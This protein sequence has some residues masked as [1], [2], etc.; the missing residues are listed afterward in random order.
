MIKTIKRINK[1]AKEDSIQMI[2]PG[3]QSTPEQSGIEKGFWHTFYFIFYGLQS[4]SGNL[5]KDD[6][7]G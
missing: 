2:S 7:N 6:K 5:D 3:T 4:L 1:Y